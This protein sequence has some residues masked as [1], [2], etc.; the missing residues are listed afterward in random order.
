MYTAERLDGR[1]KSQN[2]NELKRQALGAGFCTQILSAGLL[3]MHRCLG[4]DR[5]LLLAHDS[6]VGGNIHTWRSGSKIGLD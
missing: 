1:L 3:L 2:S 6:L 5:E 4:N